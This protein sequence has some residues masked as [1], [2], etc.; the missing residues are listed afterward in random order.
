VLPLP[1][2]RLSPRF[3]R[4][5]EYVCCVFQVCRPRVSR[6]QKAASR[7][8]YG[9]GDTNSCYSSIAL[10]AGAECDLPIAFEPLS[11]ASGALSENV[12]LTDN[13]LNASGSAQS[14]PRQLKSTL[15]PLEI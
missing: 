13:S 1:L 6:V 4:S 8:Y 12:T 15:G 5:V 11:P 10:D 14:L 7:G 3:F 9:A 2:E